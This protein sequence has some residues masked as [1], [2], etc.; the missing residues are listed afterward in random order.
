VLRDTILMGSDF[1]ETPH[2]MLE[3]D[4]MNI[5]HMSV[6]RGSKIERAIVDKNVHI[7]EGVVITDKTGTPDFD[8][9]NYYIRDGIVIIPKNAVIPAGA[10]I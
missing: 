6:G 7:G 4:A 5:P 2:E 1:F 3:E 10:K 9:P 8:G